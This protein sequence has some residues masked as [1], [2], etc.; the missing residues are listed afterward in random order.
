[1][2]LEEWKA[3]RR[4]KELDKINRELD[5][6]KSKGLQFE[7]KKAGKMKLK[8]AK[9][10]YPKSNSGFVIFLIVV[11]VI[12]AVGWVSTYFI[13]KSKVSGVGDENEVLTA[14]M[15]LKTLEMENL[16]GQIEELESALGEKEESESELSDE[17]ADLEEL[18]EI[19][20]EKVDD[21]EED[22]LDLNGEVSELKG[23]LTAQKEIVEGYEDC[24]TDNDGPF[25]VDLDVCEDYVD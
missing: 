7:G 5:D 14:E 6:L 11:I 1:M 4:K 8:E 20:Q 9:T 2:S 22:K 19:M 10:S 25:D 17:Y 3:K 16:T 15:A 21:L 23:N 18:N 12:L 24:L 13:Q